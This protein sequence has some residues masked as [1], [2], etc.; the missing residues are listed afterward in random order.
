MGRP[1]PNP[2]HVTVSAAEAA[3]NLAAVGNSV[4]WREVGT[5][6]LR[7]DES[8]TPYLAGWLGVRRCRIVDC[9]D[10]SGDLTV[11]AGPRV[12]SPESKQTIPS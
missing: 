3:Q 12:G 6:Q 10:G 2:N 8:G 5:L 7:R 11:Y 4:F 9:H 1:L